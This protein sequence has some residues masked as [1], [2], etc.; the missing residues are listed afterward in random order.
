M[1]YKELSI[2]GKIWYFILLVPIFLLIISLILLIFLSI[3]TAKLVKISRMGEALGVWKKILA[4]G[5]IK[6]FKN[7][8]IGKE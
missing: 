2:A 3:L 6:R 8:R 4:D 7:A 1:E 5:F